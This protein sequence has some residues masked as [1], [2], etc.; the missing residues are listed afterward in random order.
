VEENTLKNSSKYEIR[1]PKCVMGTT[2]RASLTQVI[3]TTK[4]MSYMD[5]NYEWDGKAY[6]FI[7]N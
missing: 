5:D 1:K 6:R 7:D 4:Y 2:R 3:I